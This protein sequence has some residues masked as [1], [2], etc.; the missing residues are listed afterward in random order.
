ML[1]HKLEIFFHQGRALL[2][3]CL[4]QQGRA[5]DIPGRLGKIYSQNGPGIRDEHLHVDRIYLVDGLCHSFLHLR[6]E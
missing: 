2:R 6:R 5:G 3:V 4:Q 1:E